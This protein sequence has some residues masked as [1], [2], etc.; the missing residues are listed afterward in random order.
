[1]VLVG[2]AE[3][4]Q[5]DGDAANKRRVI[6]AHEDH[7]PSIDPP[8]GACYAA[9][10]GRPSPPAAMAAAAGTICAPA[11]VTSRCDNPALIPK[12]QAMPRKASSASLLLASLR[13]RA[14]PK[15]VTASTHSHDKSDVVKNVHGQDS[16]PPRSASAVSSTGAMNENATMSPSEEANHMR[17]VLTLWLTISCT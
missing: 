16:T 8:G 12:V 10:S 17:L 7:G 14:G 1:I 4:A 11:L 15:A 5:R 13:P 9:P 6:L 3:H 2:D